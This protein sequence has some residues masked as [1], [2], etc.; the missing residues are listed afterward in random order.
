MSCLSIYLFPQPPSNSLFKSKTYKVC[1]ISASFT[2]CHINNFTSYRNQRPTYGLYVDGMIQLKIGGLPGIW[3]D[4][5]ASVGK[6]LSH[7]RRIM[8]HFQI[9]FHP[10][11]QNIFTDSYKMLDENDISFVLTF[12]R[13]F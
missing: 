11:L 10:P 7:N 13:S 8:T 5:V 12:C 4:L 9:L 6:I 3:C 2:L 1:P